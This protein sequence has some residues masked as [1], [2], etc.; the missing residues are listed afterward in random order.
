VGVDGS[1]A[2][3]LGRPGAPAGPTAD[4]DPPELLAR[5]RRRAGV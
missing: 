2:L 3:G 4:S 5:V 1:A